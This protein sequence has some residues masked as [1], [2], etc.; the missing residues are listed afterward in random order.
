MRS[1]LSLRFS[2]SP[3]GTKPLD[4]RRHVGGILG[5]VLKQQ[6]P[7]YERVERI[8]ASCVSL[9]RGDSVVGLRAA[10]SSELTELTST[11]AEL[12][13]VTRA[14][15]FLLHMT[16]LAEDAEA[17]ASTRVTSARGTL[18]GALA[19]VRL[20]GRTVE[21]AKA[22]AKLAH[23]SIVLTA[24]PTETS[25]KSILDTEQDISR[26][27]VA[28]ARAASSI[29]PSSQALS[30]ALFDKNHIDDDDALLLDAQIHRS[31][32]SLWTT[33]MLR[34]RKLA[35]FDEIT[36]GVSFF[37]RTFL[38]AVPSLYLSLGRLLGERDLPPTL[39][40][41]SWIGGDRDGNPFVTADTMATA[42]ELQSAVA[43]R[44]YGA[45]V[46]ALGAELACSARLINCSDKVWALAAAAVG[47]NDG[48]FKL[49]N[50]PLSSTS[51]EP[52]RTALKFIYSRL[53]ASSR[54]LAGTPLP[55]AP[56]RTS[57]PYH[58]PSEFIIDLIAIRESLEEAG[59][60]ALASGRLERLIA[61]VR[62]FGF[63]LAPLDSRQNASIHESVISEL[64][65]RAGVTNN[66]SELSENEKISVLRKE[67]TSKRPLF[68]PFHG[69]PPSARLDSELGVMRAI[70]TAH[71]RFGTHSIQ[72]YIISNC[73]SYSDLLEAAVLLKE[74]GI[75]R[76]RTAV[77]GHI[78]E[79]DID[80]VPLFETIQDL[81]I[82]ASV[83]RTAFADPLWSSLIKSRGNAAEV[84]LGYSDSCKD[85]GYLTST[86]SLYDAEL[87]L[88]SAFKD[89]HVTLRLFH[90]R[91]GSVGRGG[92][93]SFEA[94]LAQPTGACAGGLRLTEQGEVI[95]SKYA[96][97]SLGVRALES[98]LSASLE[99]ALIDAEQLGAVA[100]SF[101]AAMDELS[102][103]S[104]KAYRTLV[105]DTPEFLPYFHAAT[106]LANI[107]QLNIGSR[108]AA[109]TSEGLARVESL[110][111]IPWVFSWAQSRVMLPGWYGLGSAV[112]SFLAHGDGSQ[113]LSL[114]RRM[115]KEW[116]F[117]RTTLSNAAMVLAKSDMSVAARY[118]E[119]VPD[120]HIRKTVFNA[121]EKEHTLAISAL[122]AIKG[123][124]ELLDDQ[125]ELARS[126]RKRRAYI[127]PLNELQV[128]LI[129]ANREGRATDT[130]SLR[131]LHITINGIAAGLRNSG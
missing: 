107:T 29:S 13:N 2:L 106:P 84:M 60:G 24:H 53:A 110:R 128:E 101:H 115:D 46:H 41:G 77:D 55:R 51:D 90:G 26:A 50:E 111:A 1:S 104:F 48:G 42:F 19:S 40:V 63:H 12:I 44:H 30:A 70:A 112:K 87:G 66:Y 54:V 94:I 10:L 83:M 27:L 103:V 6:T 3:P 34:T 129:R 118:A 98:I 35:V 117:F 9:R 92:G 123:H 131:A 116:P 75:I 105:Y 95:A 121:I 21:D 97:P 125:P 76:V 67:L 120:E 64:F 127:D 81:K 126:I 47:D 33:A 43:F 68:S 114:L 80:I 130:R 113:R 20:H 49:K 59:I 57:L 85:G 58:R 86:W 99:G 28:R 32:L 73:G 5:T 89:A 108:P 79:S 7:S 74:A 96:D 102:S 8:R 65:T 45:E 124:K 38:H 15:A 37:K 119:L 91:G 61:A 4:L 71:S 39:S 11:P 18:T 31:I 52:Y 23:V 16:N 17:L 22:W 14:F 100:P 88:V 93:P 122:L 109:R 82:G 62:I 78:I 36:N 72:Q 56:T 25:R 69:G